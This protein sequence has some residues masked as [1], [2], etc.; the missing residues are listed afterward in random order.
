MKE[1]MKRQRECREEKVKKQKMGRNIYYI[2]IL[3]SGKMNQMSQEFHGLRSTEDNLHL[4][5]G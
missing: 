3:V 4:A 1:R 5:E 2:S